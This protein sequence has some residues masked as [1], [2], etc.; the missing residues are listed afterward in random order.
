MTNDTGNEEIVLRGSA[1]AG[2]CCFIIEPI[3]SI[4]LNGDAALVF[5]IVLW[6]VR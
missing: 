4:P 2:G 1:V 3:E 6:F 5:V